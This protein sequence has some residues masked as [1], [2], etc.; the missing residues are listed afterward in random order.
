MDNSDTEVTIVN[1][2]NR[3]TKVVGKKTKS[4]KIKVVRKKNHNKGNILIITIV[5]VYDYMG[6]CHNM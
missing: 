3:K 6:K 5:M 1:K 2:N 4:R